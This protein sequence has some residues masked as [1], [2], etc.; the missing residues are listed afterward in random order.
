MEV[1][2]DAKAKRA[3]TRAANQARRAAIAARTGAVRQLLASDGPVDLPFL[4]R[5]VVLTA[6]HD[7]AEAAASLLHLDTGGGRAWDAERH[8][9]I[10]Y[11]AIDPE[12]AERAA[13]AVQLAEA[14]QAA[15]AQFPARNAGDLIVPYLDLLAA[16]G[17]TK[18]P[19]DAALRQQHQRAAGEEG[20]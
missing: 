15:G 10:D 12:H 3:A 13:F 7:V 17:Y 8:A 9:L 2:P 19:G 16:A 5:S 14:E 1:E 11:A 4:C 20:A 6:R 18:L